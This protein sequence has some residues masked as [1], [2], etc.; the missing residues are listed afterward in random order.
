MET[1]IYLERTDRAKNMARYYRLTIVETLFGD[2]AM[3][4]EWGR[5]GRQGQSREHWCTTK[6][7]AAALLRAHHLERLKRGYREA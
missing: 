2:W 7:D 1:G 5:I 6:D 4:R 3:V